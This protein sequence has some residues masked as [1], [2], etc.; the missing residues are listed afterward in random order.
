M[1][2][3]SPIAISMGLKVTEQ[4]FPSIWKAPDKP[5]HCTDA[6]KLK[7]TCP[8]KYRWYA[9]RV[10]NNVPIFKEKVTL[11]PRVSVFDAAHMFAWTISV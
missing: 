9:D 8:Y 7:I 5:Y 11:G 4:E 2:E 1:L 6:S 10:E 3:N